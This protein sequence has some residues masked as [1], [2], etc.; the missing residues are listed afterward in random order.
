[1][2][3][4]EWSRPLESVGAFVIWRLVEDVPEPR[5]LTS[6]VRIE[7]YFFPYI[8][9][10]AGSRPAG[11]RGEQARSP[12]S[13]VEELL[14]LVYRNDM[15][16]GSSTSEN[17]AR[18]GGVM[19]QS[20][21]R[22]WF[23]PAAAAAPLR[24]ARARRGP[25]AGCGGTGGGKQPK[26]EQLKEW[27]KLPQ[28]DRTKDIERLRATTENMGT[29][30]SSA[31]VAD[32]A[33]VVPLLLPIYEKERDEDARGVSSSSSTPSPRLSTRCSSRASS[34]IAR[35][36]CGPGRWDAP[37]KTLTARSRLRRRTLSRA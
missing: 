3:A 14:P 22:A 1:M 10:A 7:R 15:Q 27:P 20:W 23:A 17:E 33:G 34:A 25:A 31:L 4:G 19:R 2:R 32:G 30:A 5:Q 24:R 18:S 6:T 29:E 9:E 11:D 16:A 37:R 26:L 35:R 28:L 36:A 21:I 12:R 13:G 8:P